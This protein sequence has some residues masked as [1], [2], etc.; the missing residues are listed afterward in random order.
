MTHKN[1]WILLICLAM[2][3]SCTNDPL[4]VDASGVQVDLSFVDVNNVIMDADSSELIAKHHEFKKNIENIYAYLI[5]HC[6]EIGNVA[7]TA[8]YTSI[9]AF[10]SDS[11][12]QVLNQDIKA[13]F[14]DKKQ[15]EENIIDGFRHL[16]YHL[17]DSKVPRHIVYLNSLFRSGI[18]CTEEEVG[19]GLQQYLGA[20]NEIVRQLNPEF[21][22]DWMK[23]GF[24]ARFL[25]RD[26]LTGWIETHIVEEK[27]G[28]LAE[29]IIRWGK[30]LYLTEAAFPDIEE[31]I[32]LRYSKED[33]TWA[34]ENEYP[35]WKYLMDEQLLFVIDERT[36][37][38]MIGDGPFTPGL[39]D[40]EGPDRL[41]QFIGWRMVHMYMEKNNMSVENMIK[42]PYNEILKE[43][44]ID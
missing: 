14:P 15:M 8:F 3:V 21:Y 13:K 30:I 10:R 22:Y 42:L 35:Y 43:Y 39:P 26:A 37:R 18:F 11:M 16:R 41:G 28:N 5:G 23:Q 24:E 4:D 32:L 19:I 29:N 31:Y 20:D 34:L 40:Q 36:T 9:E 25:E 2:L 7:D 33:Y 17:P 44:E 38:N 12:I 1:S 6:M 27:D